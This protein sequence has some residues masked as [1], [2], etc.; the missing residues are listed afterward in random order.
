M[1]HSSDQKGALPDRASQASSA[2]PGYDVT[3]Y[4]IHIGPHKTGSTYLQDSFCK[5]RDVLAQK[6]YPKLWQTISTGHHALAFDL[7]QKKIDDLRTGFR[8]LVGEALV[9]FSSEAGVRTAAGHRP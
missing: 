7:R 2:W 8:E 1:R 6:A 4:I 3:E 9:L 5:L